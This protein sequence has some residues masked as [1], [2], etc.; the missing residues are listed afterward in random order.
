MGSVGHTQRRSADATRQPISGQDAIELGCGTGYVSA[1]MV[2]RSA[3]FTAVDNSSNQ[4]A[5]CRRLR[6]GHGLSFKTLYC[7]A[8]SLPFTDEHFNF[9]I[10]EYSAAIWADPH[11]WIPDAHHLLRPGRRLVLL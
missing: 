2:R 3:G 1:W 11:R 10:S 9:A 4:L 8:E 6:A 7:N 5:T